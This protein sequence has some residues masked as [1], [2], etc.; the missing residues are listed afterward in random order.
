[1]LVAKR[2]HEF[3]CSLQCKSPWAENP[4][5]PQMPD[6]VQEEKSSLPAE[7]HPDPDLHVCRKKK[8]RGE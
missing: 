5:V 2:E 1:M 7:M 3:P 4:A 6:E 8:A